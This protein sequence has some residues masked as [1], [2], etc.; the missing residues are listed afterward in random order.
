MNNVKIKEIEPDY[1]HSSNA[2]YNF[3][4]EFSYLKEAIKNKALT[5]RYCEENIE[6]LDLNYKSEVLK[7]AC[8]LQ[9][10]FCDIPLHS[11]SK[12]FLLETR[13]DIEK[14]DEKI[15]KEVEGGSTHIDFYGEYGIAF[16]KKWA[17]KRNIQ[18]VQYINE[19]TSLSV[20]LKNSFEYVSSK[21][22]ISDLVVSDIISR[23]S[24][25][26]PLFGEMGRTI[27]NKTIYFFKNFY[28]ECEWRYV[29]EEKKLSKCQISSV[30][31]DK[32]TRK[33]KDQISNRLKDEKYRCLWLEF[34]YQDIRYLIVPNNNARNMLIR[35]ILG[36]N[37]DS[38]DEMQDKCLLIS[39]II[40]LEDVKKDF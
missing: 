30:I 13:D 19:N 39:K 38:E 27:E 11:I 24:F 12:K 16:S 21:D 20:Q 35:Y 6:Y 36:L 40:V 4:K 29:P 34:D 14:L 10:C 23:V 22:S 26:K 15:K 8:V 9:K 32:E 25:Y 17:K 37:V 18:P 31:F 1:V 3:M 2:I 7:K 28:D 5:P 33:F